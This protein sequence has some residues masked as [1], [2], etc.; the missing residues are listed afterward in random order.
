MFA[1]DRPATIYDQSMD[2]NEARRMQVSLVYL[3]RLGGE[4]LHHHH[5]GWWSRHTLRVGEKGGGV[6]CAARDWP[7]ADDGEFG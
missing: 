1:T 7:A 5:A 4:E 3:L 2:S 6:G